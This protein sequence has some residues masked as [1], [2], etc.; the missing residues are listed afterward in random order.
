M[1]L[2][3]FSALAIVLLSGSAHARQC[4]TYHAEQ[5]SK[6]LTAY[7]NEPSISEGERQKALFVTTLIAND[8][9][10]KCNVESGV[11]GNYYQIVVS[12]HNIW[13]NF[14]GSAIDQVNVKRTRFE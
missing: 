12:T 7:I 9:E 8:P 1:K 13:I 10:L 2:S 11:A 3:V 6:G 4:N 14:F 5:I